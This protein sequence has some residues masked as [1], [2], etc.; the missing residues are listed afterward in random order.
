M[1]RDL[2]NHVSVGLQQIGIIMIV[3]SLPDARD[4]D[5]LGPHEH[6]AERG[7]AVFA[8]KHGGRLRA[9]LH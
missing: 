7:P 1:F 8:G 2:M 4:C 3:I 6:G 9:W 5:L